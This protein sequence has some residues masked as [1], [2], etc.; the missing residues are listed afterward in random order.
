MA[1]QIVELTS[2]RPVLINWGIVLKDEN[3]EQPNA[4]QYL[5]MSESIQ[6]RLQSLSDQGYSSGEI[7]EYFITEEGKDIQFSG[8]GYVINKNDSADNYKFTY[9]VSS[10]EEK[11]FEVN[12]EL[13]LAPMSSE[14]YEDDLEV[15]L[16]NIDVEGNSDLNLSECLD[17]QILKAEGEFFEDGHLINYKWSAT[18]LD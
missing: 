8:W 2:E 11:S 10:V 15:L 13:S 17:A 1:E 16:E 12:I 9:L 5:F 14:D 4:Q 3:G 18:Q 7:M 6:E